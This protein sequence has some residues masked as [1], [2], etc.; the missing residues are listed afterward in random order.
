MPQPLRTF[1]AALLAL[2]LPAAALAQT[3][4]AQIQFGP[5]QDP[6]QPVQVTADQLSVNQAAGTALFTGHVV[7]GQGDMRMTAP[8]VQVDY[9]KATGGGRGTISLVHAKN[10]VTI[11][12]PT[13]AA[14]GKDAV[15]TV[16]TGIVVMTGDVVLTQGQ[17]AMSGQR[18][19]IDMTKGTGVMTGRVQTVFHPAAKPGATQATKP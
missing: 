4:G 16:S 10:G 15:Y 17:N 11:T 18:L 6:N 12:T 1:R 14:E 8:W 2:A 3:G 7:V 13:E 9:A 19:D 5:K